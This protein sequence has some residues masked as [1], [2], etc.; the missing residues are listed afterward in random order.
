MSENLRFGQVFFLGSFDWRPRSKQSLSAQNGTFCPAAVING[1]TLDYENPRNIMNTTKSIGLSF[2][3]IIG[4]AAGG[5]S[6]DST[7]TD[8][9]P[10]LLYYRASQLAPDLKP[11]DRDYLFG[12][13]WRGQKLPP[14]FGELVS[15]YDNEFKLVRQAAQATV[16]C[17]WGIDLSPGPMTLLPH[18]A[19]NKGIVQAARSRAAWALQNGRPA[20]ARDDLL[21]AFTL[22]RNS[23][24]DGTL[25]GALVQIAAENIVCSS[26]AENFY[27]LSPETLGQ[28]AAGIEAAP[29]R[30]TMAACVAT[31]KV[32]FHDWMAA[33]VLE[34]QKDN[35]GN[36]AKVMAGIRELF[37]LIEGAG[38]GQTPPNRWEEVSKASG[39]TSEGVL[40]L[41]RDMEPLYQ[42][43]A[44]IMAL[45]QPEYEAQA[46]GFSAEIENSSNPLVS[47]SFPAYEKCR[48]KEFVIQAQLAMLRAGMEYKLHGEAGLKSV[49]DPCGQGPFSF[50]RFVFEGVD[51]GFELKSAYAPR[52]VQEVLIFVEKEGPPFYVNGNKAGQPLAKTEAR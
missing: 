45:P 44:S 9:N 31:E 47:L 12:H 49:T 29:P 38:E 26:V 1:R 48:Q 42:K 3:I 35:P 15:R 30:R 39:G 19:R 8:I 34:L 7:R 52:G 5:L 50:E 20:D 16:P 27:Q 25:I 43:L 51:R 22:A 40:G 21:A 6:A 17:D 2:L 36:E 37:V 41:L 10:A 24:T 4:A 32:F 33:R 46:K 18:L 11:T 13:G 23:G 14:R 28:L